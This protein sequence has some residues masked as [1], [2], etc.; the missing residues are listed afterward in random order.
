MKKTTIG[1]AIFAVGLSMVSS[2]AFAEWGAKVEDDAFS[3]SKNATMVGA[4]EQSAGAERAIIFECSSDN[5]SVA[6]AEEK[7]KPTDDISGIPFELIFRVDS[8]AAIKLRGEGANRNKDYLQIVNKDA[9]EIK[10]LLAQLKQS[11][12]RLLV[13]VRSKINDV[14][15]S[16]SIGATGST[17]SVN[18]FVKACGIELPDASAS[19]ATSAKKA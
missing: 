6:Y 7:S 11:K 17:N 9:N 1:A 14:K 12:R 3:D 5:L 10:Q 13:G 4:S 15:W 16:F 8:N 19:T 2:S 18:T